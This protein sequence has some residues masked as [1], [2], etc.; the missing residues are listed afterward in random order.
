MIAGVK[1]GMGVADYVDEKKRMWWVPAVD[2]VKR[3]EDDKPGKNGSA[4]GECEADP[5]RRNGLCAAKARKSQLPCAE[6]G[7]REV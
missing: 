6:E 2:A 1:N 4:E 3:E 7:L 5:A